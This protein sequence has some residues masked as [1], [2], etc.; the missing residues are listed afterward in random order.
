MP[1]PCLQSDRYLRH[2]VTTLLA[3]PPRRKPAGRAAMPSM[4]RFTCNMTV[5]IHGLVPARALHRTALLHPCAWRSL[6]DAHAARRRAA[7]PR[8]GSARPCLAL[9]PRAR[10]RC[11]CPPRLGA[12]AGGSVGYAPASRLPGPRPRRTGRR[13]QCGGWCRLQPARS[14]RLRGVACRQIHCVV[15]STARDLHSVPAQRS[16]S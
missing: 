10:R 15:F 11:P 14:L 6:H 3:T 9:R 5:Y 1:S 12:R 13:A 2:D 4:L 16:L 8:H 7:R